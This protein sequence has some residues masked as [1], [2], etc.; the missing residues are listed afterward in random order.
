MD[1]MT[2]RPRPGATSLLMAA[3]TNFLTF[4]EE[5]PGLCPNFG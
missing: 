2:G 3:A 5:N 1:Q 4:S